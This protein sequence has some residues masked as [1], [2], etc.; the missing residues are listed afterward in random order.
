MLKVG[1]K[2]PNFDLASAESA[3]IML[4]DEISKQPVVLFFFKDSTV[5]EN[6][7]MLQALNA[8]HGEIQSRRGV[9][10]GIAPVKKLPEL[11]ELQQELKI[12]FPLLRDD[13]DFLSQYG[14]DS[15]EEERALY[16]VDEDSTIRVADRI[17]DSVE[18][19]LPLL[20]KELEARPSAASRLP[21][22]TLNR[23]IYRWVG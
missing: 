21:K 10:F 7:E 15:E 23:F 4:K 17:S 11:V 16:L 6:R 3:T 9:L 1:D 5:S 13:R 19:L 8:A 2:A 20:F 22:S 12:V 14:L 18:A